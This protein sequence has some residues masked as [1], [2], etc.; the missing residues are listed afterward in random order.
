MALIELAEGRGWER[1]AD[2]LIVGG[3]DVEEGEWGFGIVL[4]GGA[5][6][7][8]A[9][10]LGGEPWEAAGNPAPRGLAP[11]QRGG[12]SPQGHWS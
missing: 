4:P 11:G 7:A 8:V 9:K 10:R 5:A 3:E 2:P 1:P 12:N 6:A